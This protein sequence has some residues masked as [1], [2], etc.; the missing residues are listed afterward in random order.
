MTREKQVEKILKDVVR[1]LD[2]SDYSWEPN[3]NEKGYKSMKTSFEK[4]EQ[5][6]ADMLNAG[7]EQKL[8][9]EI[10]R[11]LD[12]DYSGTGS[13]RHKLNR[14]YLVKTK[15]NLKVFKKVKQDDNAAKVKMRRD[16][17]N[18]VKIKK[19]DRVENLTETLDFIRKTL[20]SDK[21][22]DTILPYA[23]LE[24]HDYDIRQLEKEFYEV[25]QKMDE[26]ENRLNV[27]ITE[28]PIN[29]PKVSTLKDC[30]SRYPCWFAYVDLPILKLSIDIIE[31]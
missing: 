16:E 30:I 13:K 28:I 18:T 21:H 12:T 17:K 1:I 23:M 27:K 3:I 31:K 10:S 14:S 7:A 19:P 4:K 8:I 25:L 24:E 9:D 26:D 6:I 22:C 29:N 20:T 15:Y 5:I 2:N 11:I